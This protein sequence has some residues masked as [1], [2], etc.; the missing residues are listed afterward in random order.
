M[1]DL[2]RWVVLIGVLLEVT[3]IWMTA[4]PASS[5][6]G[7]LNAEGHLGLLAH[8]A[9]SHFIQPRAKPLLKHHF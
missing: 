1:N 9:E 3:K 5:P 7:L 2:S 8:W 4:D 6:P